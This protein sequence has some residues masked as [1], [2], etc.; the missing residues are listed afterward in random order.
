MQDV[1]RRACMFKRAILSK[2]KMCKLFGH[3]VGHFV[4]SCDT[5]QK[6]V[7]GAAETETRASGTSRAA[8]L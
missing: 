2:L 6:G 8:R 7:G 5:G 4:P 1:P 3:N